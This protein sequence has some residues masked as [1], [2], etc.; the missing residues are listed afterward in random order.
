MTATRQYPAA[1]IPGSVKTAFARLYLVQAE[2]GKRRRDFLDEVRSA[3]YDVSK[4]SF[5]RHLEAVSAGGTGFSASKL[6]GKEAA[7]GEEER[8]LLAGWLLCELEAHRSVHLDT[9][10]RAAA[11]FFRVTLSASTASRYLA[12][13]GF[14]YKSAQGKKGGF[15]LDEVALARLAWE[16]VAARQ[17]DGIFKAPRRLCSID[18]TYTSHR[19]N[20]PSSFAP[21]GS[22][23][24][25]V[26]VRLTSYTNCIVTCVWADGANRT[27]P[28]LFTYNPEFRLD[29][30]PTARRIAQVAHL[31]SCLQAYDIEPHRIVYVGTDKGECRTYCQES[32]ELIRRFFEV[33][34]VREDGIVL[35]DKGNAFYPQGDRAL[36]P[37]GF[38]SH[39]PYPAPVHQHLSPNDNNLHGSAKASWRA[40]VDNFDDD[41]DA[42]CLLLNH[43]D[44]DISHHSKSWFVRNMMG[45]TQESTSLLISGAS[46]GRHSINNERKRNFR[47]FLGEDARDGDPSHVPMEMRDG[48]DG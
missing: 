11:T 32:P 15:G 4:R 47:I 31:R 40:M 24:P 2:G 7:L 10:G 29:R 5:D 35:S 30:P 6:S 44:Y 18:F 17:K 9:Y 26:N 27:P 48:L 8:E 12:D 36:L 19:S 39:Y 37:L 34:R 22:A 33:W 43:L 21:S 3:G 41:V 28:V 14:T 45:A 20:K 25:K 13:D 46:A 23:Q 1:T 42:C 16:W 38:A